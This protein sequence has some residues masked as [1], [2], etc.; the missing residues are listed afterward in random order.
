MR[1][2]WSFWSRPYQAH[3]GQRWSSPMHHLLAWGLSLDT[4]RRHYPETVLVTDSAGKQLLVDRLGLGFKSVSTE[5]DRLAGADPAWWA[6]GKLVAY[7]L[8]DQPFV[9][10]D[11]DVFLWKSL[12]KEVAEAP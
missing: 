10:I 1:A 6:L 2:V 8:Q 3:T 12:S 9:H 11:S 4:A 7:S 5:L